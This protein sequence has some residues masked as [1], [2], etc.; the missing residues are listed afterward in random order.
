[1]RV[2]S[3]LG[4]VMSRTEW[5]ERL[6]EILRQLKTHEELQIVS[7]LYK[8]RWYEIDGALARQFKVGEIIKWYKGK[9]YR[10]VHWGIVTEAAKPNSRYIKAVSTLGTEWTLG[11]S[12]VEKVTDSE[13]VKKILSQLKERGFKFK[14]K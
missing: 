7:K 14:V 3:I 12:V 4:V 8:K 13:R 5:I 6:T 1:M 9:K 11:G 10:R 2:L